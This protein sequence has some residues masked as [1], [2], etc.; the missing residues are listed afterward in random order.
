[1]TSAE[2]DSRRVEVEGIVCKCESSFCPALSSMILAARHKWEY[3]VKLA[4]GLPAELCMPQ[5]N[6]TTLRNEYLTE[7]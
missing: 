2:E 3:V 6:N 4:M 7:D 5:K 1:M